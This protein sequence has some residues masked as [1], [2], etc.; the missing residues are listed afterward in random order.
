[1]SALRELARPMLASIFV[2][3]GMQ[4][5]ENPEGVAPLAE[6][7]VRPMHQRIPA[8]P[9]EAEQAVRINGGIQAAAGAMLALGVLPRLAALAIAGTL[10]PTTL[11][12]HRFWEHSDPQ[13]RA[14]HRIQFLKN[15]TIM[16]G[17]L[18]AIADTDG[19]PSLT[20]RRHHATRP[21]AGL[22]HAVSD[23]ASSFTDAA[24]AAATAGAR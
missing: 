2:I 3:Q 24:Q 4:N 16:G 5:F 19:K 13:E 12:G 17:L 18:L 22:T 9:A 23:V 8:V 10:V 14:K 20:W 21:L 1:M 11:A 7:V 15:L 6:P